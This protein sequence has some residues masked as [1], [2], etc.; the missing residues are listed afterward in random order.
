MGWDLSSF[1]EFCLALQGPLDASKLFSTEMKEF[2]SSFYIYGNSISVRRVTLIDCL[3][4]C[5]F[6]KT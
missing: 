1:L 2:M 6:G 3:F 4:D 5:L